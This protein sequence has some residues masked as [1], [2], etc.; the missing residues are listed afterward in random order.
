MNLCVAV[1][2]D[3]RYH[4]F[5]A[6]FSSSICEKV[7]VF[8][9]YSILDQNYCDKVFIDFRIPSNSNNTRLDESFSRANNPYAHVLRKLTA[10]RHEANTQTREVSQNPSIPTLSRKENKRKVEN[11]RNVLEWNGVGGEWV[12]EKNPCDVNER[13]DGWIV[14]IG[15]CGG[16]DQSV[17]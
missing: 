5:A 15:D 4:P 9:S 6:G 17:G 13:H 10:R 12:M 14:G 7:V 11:D 3:T 8:S 2:H 1:G 16:Y